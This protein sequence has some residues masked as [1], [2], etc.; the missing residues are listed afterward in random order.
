M[1]NVS[2]VYIGVDISKNH[3]DFHVYPT[4]KSCRIKNEKR[5]VQKFVNELGEYEIANIGCEATGGYEKLLAKTL[6]QNSYPLWVVDPRRIKGFIT[7]SGCKS[8]T[9]KIDAKKI[10]QFVSQNSQSYDQ[11]VKTDNEEQLQAAINRKQDLT[12]FLSA[13]KTRLQHPSHALY[14]PSIKKMIKY[15]EAAIKSIEQQIEKLI[16]QDD[17]L[18]QKARILESIPGIG[19]ASAAILLSFLPELGKIGD[20]QIAALAGVCP[21]DNESGS[22]K[23]K[24]FIRGGRMIPRNALYMCALAAIKYN[25]VLKSFYDRLR[26]NNKPFKVAIVAVM[27]KLLLLAN[28]LLK[29]DELYKA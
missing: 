1:N 20:N 13:E 19:K 4:G 17:V 14:V 29:K 24:K 18:K 28:T 22:H 27:R 8:K 12:Q 3:L 9:D 6:K 16:T 11:I 23:G 10:A 25:P 2:K 26:A 7:A 5:E 15:L 21:Y